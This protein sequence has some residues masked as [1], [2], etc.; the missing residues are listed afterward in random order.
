MADSLSRH[1][2]NA[3][4]IMNDS[5]GHFTNADPN[6]LSALSRCRQRGQTVIGYVTTRN[7]DDDMVRDTEIIKAEIDRYFHFYP[8]VAGIFLDEMSNDPDTKSEF[9][10]IYNH[11]KLKSSTALVVGNPGAPATR[12]GPLNDGAWQVTDGVVADIIVV[13][14]GPYVKGVGDPEG[15]A[16]YRDWHPP[17]WVTSRPASMFANLVYR[18]PDATTTK[19]IFVTSHQQ[20]NAGWVDVSPGLYP[21]QWELLPDEA[22]FQ[23]P[24]L[25]RRQVVVQ[26][27]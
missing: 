22:V 11:V 15:A 10:V 14:E 21:D 23:S 3:V 26:P 2:L 6:Y 13:F 5:S 16:S 1:L 17:A 24:T 25:A 27:E 8:G 19:S 7:P 12:G 20:R 9:R 18:S 4:I